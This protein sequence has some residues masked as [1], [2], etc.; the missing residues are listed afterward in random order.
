MYIQNS[1]LLSSAQ[2]TQNNHIGI[3]AAMFYAL[4][5]AMLQAT[6]FYS[7]VMLTVNQAKH[8]TSN[9]NLSNFTI[10]LKITSSMW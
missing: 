6:V 2:I 4:F 9:V 7:M 8:D 10:E 1:C 3:L 5:L